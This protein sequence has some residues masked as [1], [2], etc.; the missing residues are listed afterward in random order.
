M[1]VQHSAKLP[2]IPGGLGIKPRV[3]LRPKTS[4]FLATGCHSA[5]PGNGFWYIQRRIGLLRSEVHPYCNRVYF[6]QQGVVSAFN[7]IANYS[8]WSG[9]PGKTRA[10][11][12]N[13]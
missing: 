8:W 7:E 10:S 12:E 11:S 2:G 3:V 6:G 5:I 13:F 4:K 1:S 9:D